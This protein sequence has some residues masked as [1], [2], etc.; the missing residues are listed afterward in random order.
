MDSDFFEAFGRLGTV[1]FGRF[2]TACPL[3]GGELM[4]SDGQERSR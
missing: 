3:G 4:S 2:R 1:R